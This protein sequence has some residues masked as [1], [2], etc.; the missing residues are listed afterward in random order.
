MSDAVTVREFVAGDEAAFRRLNE[1]WIT[2]Y[3][4]LEQKDEAAFANPR[5][6]IL[7]KGGRIFF[8][9]RDG[10][11]VGVCALVALRPGEFEVAKMGVT[12][13][14]QGL[15][16]GRLL[17]E[18][19]VAAGRALGATRLALDTHHSL[20]PAIRLYESVGFRR[21]AEEKL[22]PSPYERADVFMEMVL[23]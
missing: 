2:R 22:M 13:S 9:V 12:A 23:V 16:I 8:A 7:D 10:E 19:V 3:F 17:M 11:P 1:E 5:E 14:A 15:G 20:T 4:K 6:T 18:R 21:V